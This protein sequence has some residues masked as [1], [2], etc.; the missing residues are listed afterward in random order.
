MMEISGT[1]IFEPLESGFWGIV[2]ASGK[3]WRPVN[4]PDQL[5][6]QGARVEVTAREVEEDASIF[7]WGTPI[8]ILSFH[9]LPLLS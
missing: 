4:M 7:M 5:K 3:R 2:D 6:I 1:I 9:T 8:R